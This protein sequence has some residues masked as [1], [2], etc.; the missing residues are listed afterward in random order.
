M[1]KTFIDKLLG[2]KGGAGAGRAAAGK[3]RFGKREEV[4]ASVHGIDP[5]LVD[6]RAFEVVRTLQEAAAAKARRL[7][8]VSSIAD[9][10]KV[11]PPKEPEIT[12]ALHRDLP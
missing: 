12:Y 8:T 2:K 4:P 11:E 10:F 3:K 6:K 7:G 9:R 5:Q 1:I